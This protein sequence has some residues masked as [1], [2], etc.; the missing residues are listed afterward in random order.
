MKTQ[1]EAMQ[2][3]ITSADGLTPKEQTLADTEGLLWQAADRGIIST[4]QLQAKLQ[5]MQQQFDGADKGAKEFT[6][7]LSSDLSSVIGKMTD[8]SSIMQEAGKKGGQSVFQQLTQDANDFTKSLG[9][10]LLKLL[11]I[12]DALSFGA[13]PGFASGGDFDVT[14]TGG[15][16]S[17]RVSFMAT[18]GEHVSVMNEISSRSSAAS[19]RAGGG[20]RGDVN[21]SMPI[22]GVHADSFRATKDQIMGDLIRGISASRRYA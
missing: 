9:E 7:G 10:L 8:F 11:I 13:F 16:D 19:N 6:S 5:E 20:G 17:K 4:T 22:S 21:I 1:D 3:L 18:P 15:T 12:M 14:G 2:K